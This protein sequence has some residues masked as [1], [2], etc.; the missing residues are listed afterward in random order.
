MKLV[1][2]RKIITAVFIG[3]LPL[4]AFAQRTFASA[5]AS[6]GRTVGS[7]L[8]PLLFAGALTLFIWGVVDFIRSADNPEERK[9]G[10]KRILW[11]II[12]LF[13]MVGFLGLVSVLTESVFNSGPFLPQLAT[14]N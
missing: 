4:S 9:K 1:T 7:F 6:I 2:F 3:L 13:A 5:V 10:K 11:G 8:M 12:G 14:G